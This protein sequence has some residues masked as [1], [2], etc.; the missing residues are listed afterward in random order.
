M[1]E[2]RSKCI[3]DLEVNP[4]YKFAANG[5]WI[6]KIHIIINNNIRSNFYFNSSPREQTKYYLNTYKINR[7]TCSCNGSVEDV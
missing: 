6:F 1:D 5:Y 3:N 4:G 7:I 2:L